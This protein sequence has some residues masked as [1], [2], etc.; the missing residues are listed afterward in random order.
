EIAFQTNLLALNAAVE[1][2]RAGEH[3]KGF[4]V[5]A[6]EVRK[7]AE[8]S[9]LAAD[10]ISKLSQSTL[11]IT[12]SASRRM[13]EL[14]PEIEKTS[15]LIQEISAASAEQNS[16][17]GQINSAILQLNDLTQNNASSSEQMASSAEELAA[18][19]KEL[20]DLVGIFR[21]K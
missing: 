20:I 16:G 21:T 17:A 3:G 10:E 13:D 14:I 5:V 4:A 8:R 15:Q 6:A 18:K 7:L 9:R 19:S 11:N 2:A 12:T 1:A